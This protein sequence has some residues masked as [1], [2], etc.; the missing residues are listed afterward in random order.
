MPVAGLE[1]TERLARLKTRFLRYWPDL[2]C[3]LV[4]LESRF[5]N[6]SDRTLVVGAGRFPELAG[7]AVVNI[8]IRPF[9]DIKVVCDVQALC[10]RP[11]VFDSIVCHQVLEHVA[12]A[13]LAVAQMYH[14]LKPSGIL[15]ATVPFYFPF[16]AS[17]LDFRRWTV[18]GL[19]ATFKHFEELDSGMHVGPVSAALTAIQHFTGLLAPGFYLSYAV[20]GVLGYGLFLF[21]YLDLLIARLPHAIDMAA[22]VFYVGRKPA[23]EVDRD[24]V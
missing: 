12:D 8:D 16:H 3:R 6:P 1:E 21:K 24:G 5:L 17:P 18:P 22:S 9:R 13:D 14:V 23:N 11:G 7:T 19:H 4:N 20:K 15:I 10:F 2:A